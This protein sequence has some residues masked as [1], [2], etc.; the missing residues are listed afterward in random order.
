MSIIL[1]LIPAVAPGQNRCD[2][3]QQDLIQQM[4]PRSFHPRI[5]QICKV[6]HKAIQFHIPP[7]QAFIAYF[8][9]DAFAL[10]WSGIA[11]RIANASA[12]RNATMERY[13]W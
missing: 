5:T 3:H 12:L 9:Q 13:E 8:N 2:G 6:L 11:A 4:F 10:V 1:D 7:P